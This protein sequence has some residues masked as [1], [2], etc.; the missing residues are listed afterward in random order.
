[1]RDI[2]LAD[3]PVRLAKALTAIPIRS[4]LKQFAKVIGS[5]Q[6]PTRGDNVFIFATPRSGST[7]LMELILSQPGFRACEQPLDLRNPYVR[8]HLGISN[9]VDLY[10]RDADPLLQ[11]YFQKICDGRIRGLVTLGPHH[12]FVSR[13]L[14]FK[15]QN[16]WQ[17]RIAWMRDTFGGRIVFLIRHPVAVTVSRTQLPRLQAFRK[18][19]YI[20]H[21]GDDIIPLAERIIESG[22]CYEKGILHWCFE[23]AL[24]L[25]V[26]ENDWI[27]LTY[28]QLVTDPQSV[29]NY[30]S[31]QLDLPDVKQMMDHLYYPSHTTSKST[32]ETQQLLKARHRQSLITKWR[33]QICDAQEHLAFDIIRSFGIGAY[34]F[35]RDMPA[36]DYIIKSYDRQSDPYHSGVDS[37]VAGS[38]NA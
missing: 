17:E 8:R 30:L 26:V 31:N 4:Q 7:W 2:N 16:G 36:D 6:L 33:R 28:E 13:R 34:E 38:K 14:V 19:D 22:S 32:M 11:L 3:Q 35:G 10:Q 5:V 21:F 15:I 37:K 20:R 24:P 29:L 27:I 12:R 23:N 9:W 1:M 18:S 25:R